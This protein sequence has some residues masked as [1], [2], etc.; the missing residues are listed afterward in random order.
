MS[1]A[2]NYDGIGF[3]KGHKDALLSCINKQ[4]NNYNSTE[5]NLSHAAGDAAVKSVTVFFH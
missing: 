3:E 4:Y 1:L 2:E 5:H